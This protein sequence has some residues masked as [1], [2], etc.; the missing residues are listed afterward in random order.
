MISGLKV[1]RSK[2][3]Q[4]QFMKMVTSQYFRVFYYGI[5][6]W[7]DALLKKDKLKMVTRH[8]KVLRVAVKDWG[9]LCPR[10]MLDTLD[11]VIPQAFAK[12]AF[13]SVIVTTM[14]TKYPQ[15]LHNTVWKIII[16]PQG[17]T[18]SHN[19]LTAP[20]RRLGVNLQKTE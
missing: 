15:R 3:T 11:R 2:L 20:G 14:A 16:L 18:H 12:Y 10:N 17:A 7:Y 13:G 19:F 8:N 6:V 9:R 5:P 4:D 1:I